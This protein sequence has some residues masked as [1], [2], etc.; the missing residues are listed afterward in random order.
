VNLLPFFPGY[1]DVIYETGREPAFVMLMAF[2]LTFILTRG[3]TRLARVRGWGSASVGGVHLHHLVVGMVLAFSAGALHFAFMPEEGF[4]QLFLAAAFGSGVALVLD[5]FALIFRLEDVY[6]SREGRASVDAVIISTALGALLLLHTAPLDPN[7]YTSR[8]GVSAAV[9]L[10]GSLVL[11]TA[12][13][14]KLMTAAVG[15]FLPIF[16]LVGA[17]RLAKPDSLWARRRYKD[18][19]HKRERC[20]RRYAMY[21]ARFGPIGD[22][23]VDLIGGAPGEPTSET[24]ASGQQR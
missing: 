15:V 3:Y 1:E 11:V 5:E 8:Y 24:R 22:K 20:E 12:L 13:K 14:G 4:W 6:W 2:L 9:I 23:L 19:G 7:E 16:A 18:G 17:I 10:N 21:A